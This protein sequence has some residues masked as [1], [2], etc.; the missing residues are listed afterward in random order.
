MFK[1][2]FG[3]KRYDS[4]TSTLSVISLPSFET[5]L[6]NSKMSFLNRWHSC[7]NSLV[8]AHRSMNVIYCWLYLCMLS[9]AET[10]LLYVC[11]CVFLLLIYCMYCLYLSVCLSPTVSVDMGLLTW[12]KRIEWNGRP[13]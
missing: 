2:I 9:P 11:F 6:H 3:Y 12:N 10:G 7:A 13:K 5:V 8:A 4:V 1:V